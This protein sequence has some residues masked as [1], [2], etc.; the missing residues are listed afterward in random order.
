M[1]KNLFFLLITLFL[2]SDTLSA[3]EKSEE[4]LVKEGSIRFINYPNNKKNALLYDTVNPYG[5]YNILQASFAASYPIGNTEFGGIGES[6]IQKL[7]ECAT[8]PL[9][10]LPY[11]ESRLGPQGTTP[12]ANMYNEDSVVRIPD[13]G[14]YYVYPER[15][16]TYFICRKYDDL[17][18]KEKKVLDTLTGKFNFEP[19]EIIL[20]NRLCFSNKLII[21][22]RIDVELIYQL[23]KVIYL[24]IE[25]DTTKQL[26]RE[27]ETFLANAEKRFGGTGCYQI[28]DFM[29][30]Y[31]FQKDESNLFREKRY[32]G[33]ERDFVLN[34][35]INDEAITIEKR[36]TSILVNEYGEDSLVFDKQTKEWLLEYRLN[37]NVDTI[38]YVKS[39]FEKLYEAH[40]LYYDQR[41]KV[42]REYVHSVFATKKVFSTANETIVYEMNEEPGRKPFTHNNL[43]IPTITSYLKK[44]HSEL[45]NP[46]YKYL[47]ALPQTSFP[48]FPWEEKLYTHTFSGIEI[49]SPN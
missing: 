13:L 33:M 11:L 49:K 21:T 1:V 46:L 31:D 26:I 29:R 41:E 19:T 20:R 23:G 43:R 42:W 2:V 36:D 5:F 39:G 3:Q 24:P 47:R 12:L 40:V 30:F 22:A 38:Y 48:K 44:Q 10:D 17:V 4:Q 16:T 25:S 7:K 14:T 28:I 9:S 45:N 15:K 18:I 37:I 32:Y 35:L 34:D 6:D 8:Q 27:F